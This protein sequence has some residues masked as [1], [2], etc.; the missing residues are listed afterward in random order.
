[1]TM[2]FRTVLSLFA[3]LWTALPS[4]AMTMTV[5]GETVV[6][7]GAVVKADCA[8]LEALLARAKVTTVVLTNSGGGNADSGYCIGA[9][10]RSRGLSTV[11]RGRCASSC[12][13]MWLGGVRRSLDGPN[14]RVGLHGNYSSTGGLESAAPQKLRNWIP[15]F[16]PDVDKI[17][18]EEWIG[19]PTNKWMMYFYN[20]RAELCQSSDCK[21]IEGR[22]VRNAGLAKF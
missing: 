13:R 1:M 3:I 14:S 2:T 21:P 15:A 8:D 22:N 12:S 16:A 9:L 20:D 18:M 19:L 17:L 11:I 6:L 5:E 4:W 10:V 7:S